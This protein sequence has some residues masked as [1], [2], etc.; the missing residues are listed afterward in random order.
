MYVL[1]TFDNQALKRRKIEFVVVDAR[2]EA[3]KYIQLHNIKYFIT[4]EPFKK[5]ALIAVGIERA[6]IPYSQYGR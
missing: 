4:E 2:E 1:Y 5:S 6:K 3:L